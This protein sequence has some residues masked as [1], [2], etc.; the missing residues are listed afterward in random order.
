MSL[1]FNL[2]AEKSVSRDKGFVLEFEAK[3]KVLW[4]G[5]K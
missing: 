1:L 4:G 3:N 2:C 5:E